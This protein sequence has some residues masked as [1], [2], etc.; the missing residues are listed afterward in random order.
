MTSNLKV[1]LL[2]YQTSLLDQRNS[3]RSSLDAMDADSDQCWLWK[4]VCIVEPSHN[5]F[6]SKRFYRSWSSYACKSLISAG[7]GGLCRSCVPRSR[8]C[9]SSHTLRFEGL[10]WGPLLM[11]VAL[12]PRQL[13]ARK[14]KVH[15]SS[16][17][18][19]C[20]S[21]SN[22]HCQSDLFPTTH[23]TKSTTKR[24]AELLVWIYASASAWRILSKA[25]SAAWHQANVG[26]KSAQDGLQVMPILSCKA[27]ANMMSHCCIMALF[28]SLNDAFSAWP[29]DDKS[30]NANSNHLRWIGV[31]GPH[32]HPLVI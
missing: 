10:D 21:A 29:P 11:L 5:T 13:A 26:N 8:P 23:T 18:A 17:H 24:C 4:L 3:L 6:I 1:N 32:E 31:H 22:T 19:A 12:S 14:A 27:N 2:R 25:D 7:N 9:K 15:N 28:Q 20:M 16:L 30:F